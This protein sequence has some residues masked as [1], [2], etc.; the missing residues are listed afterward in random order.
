MDR[1][2]Y[3]LQE[4]FLHTKRCRGQI[5]PNL[6]FMEQLIAFEKALA[7]RSGRCAQEARWTGTFSMQEYY[8]ESLCQMGFATDQARRG[9]AMSEGRF[10]LALNFCL[11]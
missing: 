4:A 8:V 3:T 6:G 1:E 11:M 10:D 7:V 9:V 2:V 5:G